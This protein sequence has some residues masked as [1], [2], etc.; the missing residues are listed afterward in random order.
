MKESS[1]IAALAQLLYDFLPGSGNNQTAFPLAA[2]KAGVGE[3]WQPGSKLPSLTQLLTLTLEWKRGQFCPLILEIVRQ[4]MTWRGRRDPLKR[5]E[6][7]QLNKLLPGVG[8]QIPELL[9]PDFLDTLAGPPAVQPA[10][11]GSGKPVIDTNRL[12]EL[13]K[14]LSD[15]S[16]ISPQERG[17]AFERFLYDLFDVYGLAPRASFRPRTGEQ[18]DGSF[19]LDG[20]T[21]LLEAKWHSNPTPAADLHV[22]SSK[23]NS[24]PIWSRALFIS[25][26]GFSP[27]GL[28]AFN[29]G[30]N[31]L[32]CMDGYDLY[33]TISRE[34][35]L[36]QV[37]ATKARR[38]V[39]TGLCHV[40]VRDLF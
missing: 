33:E 5:E 15:L 39:E 12:A 20:D 10:P 36:G 23:L 24:R 30:K 27:D 11:V 14:R 18:I 1:A 28:E 22:L 21:Y 38:A 7:D 16:A 32:I 3:Y 4:S 8:F 40:S 2:H 17:F 9:D 35:S 37:I 31:S 25:Y 6:V 26:S 34:L 19:D 13:S 29:R